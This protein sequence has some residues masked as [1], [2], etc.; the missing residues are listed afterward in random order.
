MSNAE[1]RRPY[2]ERGQQSLERRYW[3]GGLRTQ[4]KQRPEAT[5]NKRASQDHSRGHWLVFSQHAG[6]GLEPFLASC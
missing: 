3:L 4:Q 5:G 6:W 2:R 1:V